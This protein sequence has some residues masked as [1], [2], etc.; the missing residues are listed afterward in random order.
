MQDQVRDYLEFLTAEKGFS[1]NTRQAYQ[2]DLNQL[3]E[4]AEP[5]AGFAGWRGVTPGAALRLRRHPP[6]PRLRLDDHR[7][8][9][10]GAQVLLQLLG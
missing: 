5:K 2:N 8:Q 10:C 4:F 9:D 1:L 3:C 7:P 6:R